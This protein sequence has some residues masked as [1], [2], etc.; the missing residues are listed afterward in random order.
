[1]DERMLRAIAQDVCSVQGFYCESA[2]FVPSDIV[3]VR[4]HHGR[5]GI[6]LQASDLLR[7]LSPEF[8]MEFLDSAFSRAIGLW[9][10]MTDSLRDYLGKGGLVRSSRK[11]Y[12][13]CNGLE[14]S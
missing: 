9:G 14:S 11:E 2:C 8:M 4:W 7:G 1:M 5:E 12:V 6:S 3:D 13:E 10:Y